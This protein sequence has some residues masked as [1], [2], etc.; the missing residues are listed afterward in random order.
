[1]LLKN[2][3]NLDA[4]R[5]AFFQLIIAAP[6]Y[7]AFL[8]GLARDRWNLFGRGDQGLLWVCAPLAAAAYFWAAMGEPTAARLLAAMLIVMAAS[9]FILAA[10]QGLMARVGQRYGMT[11][12]L[13][14]LWN[15][16]GTVLVGISF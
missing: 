14:T 7:V 2:R 10:L 3:L 15:S 11:G 1:W 6:T 4:N 8:F 12:M 13:S 5:I 16:V 9:R